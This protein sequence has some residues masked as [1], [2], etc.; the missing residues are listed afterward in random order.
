MTS[1]RKARNSCHQQSVRVRSAAP[2]R[3][4]SYQ[5]SGRSDG[6]IGRFPSICG[7]ERVNERVAFNYLVRCHL[8][9]PT[10]GFPVGNLPAAITV[11]QRKSTAIAGLFR[12]DAARIR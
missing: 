7:A 12:G 10:N 4:W 6:R 8:L 9:A 3:Q 11:S 2:V 1:D 5:T